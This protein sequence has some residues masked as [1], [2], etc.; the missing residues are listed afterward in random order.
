MPKIVEFGSSEGFS[1][2][3]F[4][5]IF[6]NDIL[7]VNLYGGGNFSDSRY[8]QIKN[9]NLVSITIDPDDE[10][11]NILNEK[12]SSRAIFNSVRTT[13]FNLN[14]TLI[15]KIDND[16][17]LINSFV[18]NDEN[19]DSAEVEYKTK[20]FVKFYPVRYRL[21]EKNKWKNIK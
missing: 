16:Y 7:L 13:N 8:Y 6:P 14:A 20:D 1:E 2:H 4:G 11:Y 18:R 17:Y 9:D 21:D 3:A 5:E 19:T 12:I 10:F 15:R